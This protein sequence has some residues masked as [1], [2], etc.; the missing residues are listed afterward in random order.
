MVNAPEKKA[1]STALLAQPKGDVRNRAGI[2]NYTAHWDRDSTKD[3]AANT[4]SRKEAYTDVVNGYYDGAT[5]SV[6]FRDSPFFPRSSP[7]R[8]DCTSTAGERASV[9]HV[10]YKLIPS[11]TARF[12]AVSFLSI[13]QRRSVL[14]G[15]R[16]TRALPRRPDRHQ[17]EYESPRRRLRCR[18]AGA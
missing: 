13:L 15:D 16:P 3:T 18:R 17:A 12:A 4:E 2:V 1:T 7:L 8:A 9:S 11:L 5:Q 14:P 6:P 10:A